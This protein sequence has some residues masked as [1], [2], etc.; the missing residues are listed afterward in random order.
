M[1]ACRWFAID[2]LTLLTGNRSLSAR[3]RA[4][5]FTIDSMRRNVACGLPNGVRNRL[6]THSLA[7]S[8]WAHGIRQRRS[9]SAIAPYG[10]TLSL[11][12]FDS[13]SCKKLP[14]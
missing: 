1:R 8:H 2:V 13:S 6:L 5:C 14:A 4:Y 12:D 3:M 11:Y 7:A 10:D 9:R